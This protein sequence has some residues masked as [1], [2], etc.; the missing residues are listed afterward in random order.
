MSLILN[1]FSFINKEY[2]IFLVIWHAVCIWVQVQLLVNNIVWSSVS[3]RERD[4]DQDVF[5]EK[6]H[7]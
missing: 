4:M 1:H 2:N 7:A 3:F 5:L 6:K